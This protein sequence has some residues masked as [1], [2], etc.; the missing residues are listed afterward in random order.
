MTSRASPVEVGVRGLVVRGTTVVLELGGCRIVVDPCFAAGLGAPGLLRAPPPATAPDAVGAV[1]LVL[2]THGLPGG[3]DPA[4][5]GALDL[6]DGGR[7]AGVIVPDERVRARAL[8]AGS[9]RRVRVARAGDVVRRGGVRVSV[10]PAAIPGSAAVGFHID[11]G[12][13]ARVWH[14][15]PLP[16]LDVAAEAASFAADHPADLVLG[17][18]AGVGARGA[19]PAVTAGLLDVQALARLARAQ[20]LVPLARDVDVAPILAGALGAGGAEQT[21]DA[22][23]PPVVSPPP[24]V[25]WSR[26][27]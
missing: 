23:G 4:G 20:A 22:A 13:G 8:R 19:A 27:R 12:P 15:G 16:P 5:Y 18:C 6:R 3:F 2:I 14:T 7:R 21:P 24:G 9:C 10:S 17:V 26:A 1:D 25:W 11:G